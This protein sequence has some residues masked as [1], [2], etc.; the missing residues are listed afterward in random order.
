MRRRPQRRGCG[1]KIEQWKARGSE[2][3]PGRG[4]Y[5]HAP[6]LPSSP[7]NPST[8]HQIQ[9]VQP[10]VPSKG[11]RPP[12]PPHKMGSQRSSWR[13]GSGHTLTMSGYALGARRNISTHAAHRT[14]VP[15]GQVGVCHAEFVTNDSIS[16]SLPHY[17]GKAISLP[18]AHFSREQGSR[19]H[20]HGL[21]RASMPA[22]SRHSWYTS[23]TAGGSE[24]CL[25]H[26][27]FEFYNIRAC[28]G[29]GSAL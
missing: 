15:G 12:T 18:S 13:M 4:A 11:R 19:P 9:A 16:A 27:S 6:I 23:S 1:L 5:R 29:K 26:S 7:S 14:G 10:L 22:L 17:S 28:P 8:H 25:P 2:V 20:S 24:R 3:G 21:S